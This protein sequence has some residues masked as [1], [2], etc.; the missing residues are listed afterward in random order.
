[1]NR[2]LA[3]EGRRAHMARTAKQAVPHKVK[4][5]AFGK[6]DVAAEAMMEDNHVPDPRVRYRAELLYIPNHLLE[7]ARCILS[8]ADTSVD[9]FTELR[10]RLV[11]LLT[12]SLLNQCTS[13][14]WGAELGG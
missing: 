1:M 5:L 3:L 4:L 10:D 2:L 7:R 14:L 8:L 12:P 6:K 13:I 9:P 11:E